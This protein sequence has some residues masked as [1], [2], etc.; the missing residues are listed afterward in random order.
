MA[1]K[2]KYI[3][4]GLLICLSVQLSANNEVLRL[5]KNKVD[6]CFSKFK[7]EYKS[8]FKAIEKINMD[9][10]DNYLHILF[11]YN[12][13]LDTNKHVKQWNILLSVLSASER[14]IEHARGKNITY[15]PNIAEI[16]TMK[17]I[18]LLYQKKY[19]EA[20]QLFDTVVS[21][22]EHEANWMDA[23][24]WLAH[25]SVYMGMYDTAMSMLQSIAETLDTTNIKNLI[26]YETIS[27]DFSLKTFDYESALNHLLKVE[28][29]PLSRQTHARIKFIIAQ[30]YTQTGRYVEA[31]PYYDEVMKPLFGVNNLMKSYSVVYKHFCENLIKELQTYPASKIANEKDITP[32]PEEFE[33][34]I[35][36]SYH[37]SSYIY[38]NYPYYFNDAAAM[39]FL[40]ESIENEALE[41]FDAEDSTNYIDDYYQ[42]HLT[43]EM[44]EAIFDNWDSISIHIPKTD[45]SSMPDTVY[46]PLIEAGIEYSLPHF[47][48]VF[49][50]FGWRRYRYHYG[51]DTKNSIGDSI[52]SVFDGIVRI[53][54]RNRTYG[55]IIIVRHYNGLETFYAHCSKL[56]V[57]QNQEVKAGELIA[58]VGSTGRSTG[59]HLHFETRYKGTAFN[60][61]YMIDFENGK[62]ISDTLMITKETFNYR[63]SGNSSDSSPSPANAVYYKI[64]P[65]DT[66]SGIAKKYRTNVKN[67]KR[68][69]RLKSDFIREGQ[70]IRVL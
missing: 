12:Y 53:A 29:L 10:S 66:L 61:E 62:L 18:V 5:K 65:G 55:N 23:R 41:L 16:Y 63:R 32:E 40:D 34:T 35:I 7:T 49:S 13:H 43:N 24:L 33:P 4:L 30:I 36:E 22:Y 70:R 44:L 54:K 69:N 14:A 21:Y 19:R 56:L 38:M 60:P 39:F 50:R 27:A 1:L 57:E 37:D 25:T 67:I 58:L 51:I 59:P 68:L 42:M 17:G 64:R 47:N 26:R 46:L 45:F 28:T 20:Y 31:I 6:T 48:P 11:V 52:F 9:Y 2:I 8:L 3:L 15:C